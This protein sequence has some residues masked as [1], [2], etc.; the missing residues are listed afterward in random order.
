MEGLKNA[1]SSKAHVASEALERLDIRIYSRRLISKN[2]L[3]EA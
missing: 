1:P 2:H 3:E